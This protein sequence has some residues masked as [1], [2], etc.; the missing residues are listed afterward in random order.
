MKEIKT[1]VFDLG[2]IFISN[3]WHDGSQEKIDEFTKS[4]GFKPEDMEKAWKESK[5]DYLTGKINENEFWLR[6]LENAGM[7]EPHLNR[8]INCKDLYR[9]Y[10]KNLG[11]FDLLEN[12]K[13]NRYGLVGV[14][15]T[16]HEWLQHKKETFALPYYFWDISASCFYGVTKSEKEFYNRL[17]ATAKPE[18][19]LF[20]DDKESNLILAGD[21]GYKN[22]ILYKDRKQLEADLGKFGVNL[23]KTNERL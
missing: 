20:V 6:F 1:I 7:V 5:P 22:T 18:E 2:N 17:K 10:L 12:L 19:S 23:G 9:K 15:N 13:N 4:F 21:A 3:D 16:G 14:T 11:N 8:I